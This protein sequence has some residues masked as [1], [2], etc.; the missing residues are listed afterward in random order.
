MRSAASPGKGRCAGAVLALVCAIVAAGPAA[1]QPAADAPADDL[2]DGWHIVRPDESLYVIAER[3][4]GDPE[5]WRLLARLNPGIHDPDLIRPG[6]RLRVR[7][8]SGVSPDTAQMSRVSRRV[9]E[10]LRPY[11]WSP[12]LEANFL[13]TRDGVRTFE[14][15][16]AELVFADDSRLVITE[17]TLVFLGRRGEV[18]QSVRRDEIEVVVGQADL[19]AGADANYDLLIGD[20]LLRP[21]VGADGRAQAR[22]R[23]PEAGGAELMVFEGESVVE[24]GGESVPVA[25][26]MGTVVKKGEPPAPPEKLLPA[27][28]PLS[29]EAG[30]EWAIPNP[31]FDWQPLEGA[32]NY[33]VEVCRDADCTLLEARYPALEETSFKPPPL[34]E[35]SYFWRLTAV[36]PSGLDGYPSAA[37]EFSV[38]GVVDDDAPTIAAELSGRQFEDDGVLYLGA[39]AEL[40]VEVDDVGTGLAASYAVVDGERRELDAAGPPWDEGPHSIEIVAEDRAGNRTTKRFDFHYDVTPPV[41]HLDFEGGRLTDFSGAATTIAGGPTHRREGWDLPRLV[42]SDERGRWEIVDGRSVYRFPDADSWF[43]L[44]TSRRKQRLYFEAEEYVRLTP[45]RQ[46][47]ATSDDDRSGVGELRFEVEHDF[48]EPDRVR[49]LVIESEDRVGNLS[50]AVLE[51]WRGLG[52]GS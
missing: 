7:V 1:T 3:Y 34:E 42:W 32:S 44:R 20:S 10:Q 50:R 4:L 23:R 40:S 27:P 5:R 6:Q 37:R 18:E 43:A 14:A 41:I 19:D 29:P 15:S 47:R 13:N 46:V 48:R 21:Q 31:R 30:S 12:A 8:D 45:E 22:A 28:Q 11:D 9:E 2:R 26:G 17:D 52:S 33:V 39:D 24:A 51:L 16:S 49:T 36:A 25:E 35:G 38:S